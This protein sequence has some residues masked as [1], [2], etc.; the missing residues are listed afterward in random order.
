MLMWSSPSS[1]SKLH[2][3][4]NERRGSPPRGLGE[5]AWWRENRPAAAD[6][7]VN[8]LTAALELLAGSPGVGVVH[9]TTRTRLVRRYL[10][11]K[12]QQY[13]FYWVDEKANT[14]RV[15]NV[16]SANRGRPPVIR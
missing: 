13:V 7:V 9:K 11:Q 1:A 15:M 12:S 8:E 5:N 10:L 2:E 14:L 16:W 3:S 6:L 4:A